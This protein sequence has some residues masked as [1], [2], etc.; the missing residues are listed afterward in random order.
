MTYFSSLTKATF[1]E[2]E[3]TVEYHLS[4]PGVGVFGLGPP[5][6][7]FWVQLGMYISVASTINAFCAAIVWFGVVKQRRS[8][9]SYLLTY[10][11]VAPLMLVLPYY[12][13]SFFEVQN[14]VLSVPFIVLPPLNIL[15]CLEG[16]CLHIEYYLL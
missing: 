12:L 15:R 6:L 11:V 2:D 10:G 4:V 9:T 3:R 1:A 7:S 14:V 5:I 13:V 8:T 16:K